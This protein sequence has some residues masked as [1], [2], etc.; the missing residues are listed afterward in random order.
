VNATTNGRTVIHL[1]LTPSAGKTQIPAL[2][3]GEKDV[4]SASSLG[5][6]NYKNSPV[7]II[8]GAGYGD[9]MIE[10]MRDAAKG[11]KEVPWLRPDTSKPAPPIG[12]E[13]GKAMVM[14][15]KETVEV[16]QER[17][18]LGKGGVVWY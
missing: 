18:D 2:L 7:A 6:K 13:Y 10:Q 1:I 11:T 5:S 15:I 4:P 14:R 17:G 12:P 9:E 3:R 8:L 16:L